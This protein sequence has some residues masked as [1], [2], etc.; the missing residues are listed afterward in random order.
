MS[1]PFLTWIHLSDRHCCA[2]WTG[3]DAAHVTH[4]LTEDL[5]ELQNSRGLVPECLFFTGDLAFGEKDPGIRIADQF[6]EGGQF[7]R[8]IAGAVQPAIPAAQV[9]LVPGN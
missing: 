2:P 7:L 9:F 6:V 3:V 8:A 5:R 4:T 1:G